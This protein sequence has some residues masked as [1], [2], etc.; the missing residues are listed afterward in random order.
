MVLNCSSETNEQNNFFLNKYSRKERGYSV[1]VVVVSVAVVVSV[2][3]Y[4]ITIVS[5]AMIALNRSLETSE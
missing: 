2:V 1:V 3:V 5:K 4:T